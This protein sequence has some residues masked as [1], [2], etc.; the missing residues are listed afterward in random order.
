MS[1]TSNPFD[2]LNIL[3]PNV[4]ANKFGIKPTSS[5]WVNYL[6]THDPLSLNNQ[7]LSDLIIALTECQK[8]YDPTIYARAKLFFT[9]F[10][11]MPFIREA[12]TR[13]GFRECTS[14]WRVFWEFY[15]SSLYFSKFPLPEASDIN[16]TFLKP[17]ILA[18]KAEQQSL[19][20]QFTKGFLSIDEFRFSGTGLTDRLGD[21]NRMYA[22][23]NCDVAISQ[24]TTQQ[25]LAV[26]SD[27]TNTAAAN[28]APNYTVYVIYGVVGLI[29]LTGVALFFK[30]SKKSA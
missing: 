27:A 25:D 3:Y 28:T 5:D 21:L 13:Y 7:D 10:N 23:L 1:T 20:E 4:P 8:K 2:P 16:C 15:F 22:N 26:L 19:Q 12:I 24:Q 29:L 30:K 14:D 9:D 18:V 17:L 6:S 11:N